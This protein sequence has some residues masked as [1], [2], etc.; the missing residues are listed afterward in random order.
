MRRMF[1][2]TDLEASSKPGLGWNLHRVRLQRRPIAVLAR[3]LQTG[4]RRFFGSTKATTKRQ[5]EAVD[6]DERE[7]ASAVVAAERAASTSPRLDDVAGRCWQEVGQ[8]HAGAANT[9]K[10]IEF[11]G[12]NK[13]I[14][15]SAATRWLVA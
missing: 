5:A 1:A 4:G 9:R 3:W 6:R 2:D 12:K 11:F 13:L 7:K 14:T 8:H 10:L 15:R